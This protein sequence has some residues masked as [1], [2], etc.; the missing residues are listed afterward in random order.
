MPLRF[1]W[2]L[3]LSGETAIAKTPEATV[4]YRIDQTSSGCDSLS[5]SSLVSLDTLTK[6]PHH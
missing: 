2:M 6:E 3:P 5:S 1:H 4:R